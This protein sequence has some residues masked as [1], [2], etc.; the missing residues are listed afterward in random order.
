MTNASNG[1]YRTHADTQKIVDALNDVE[2]WAK[3]IQRLEGKESPDWQRIK[4]CES[5][6][7]EAKQTVF[8]L[9]TK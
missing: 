1:I 9:C 8:E 6:L 7:T 3:G 5:W 4:K 2:S